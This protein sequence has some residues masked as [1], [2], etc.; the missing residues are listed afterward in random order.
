MRAIQFVMPAACPRDLYVPSYTRVPRET[1]FSRV[2]GGGE[3]AAGNAGKRLSWQPASSDE[4]KYPAGK[5]SVDLIDDIP[6]I[7]SATRLGDWQ[8]AI[9]CLWL[10]TSMVTSDATRR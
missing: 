10:L 3:A 5:R 8:Y 6:L 1:S 2:P 7:D 9:L 4:R